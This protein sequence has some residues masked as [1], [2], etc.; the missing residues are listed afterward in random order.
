MPFFRDSYFFSFFFFPNADSDPVAGGAA[1]KQEDWLW[2]RIHRGLLGTHCSPLCQV[3]PRHNHDQWWKV[4]DFGL[5]FHVVIPDRVPLCTKS[6]FLSGKSFKL[7]QQQTLFPLRT[8][9]STP[10]LELRFNTV[11]PLLDVKVTDYNCCSFDSATY[12]NDIALLKLK[13]LPFEDKC[14]V[15]NP[16][17]SAVCVPWSTQLFQPNHTCS[18]SGWGR[19]AGTDSTQKRWTCVCVFSSSWLC[20]RGQSCSGSALGQRLPHRKLWEFLQAS[21]QARNDVCRWV[22]AAPPPPHCHHAV[23]NCRDG[24]ELTL[25]DYLFGLTQV[26]WTAAWTRVRETVVVPWSARTSWACP[27]CGASSAGGRGVVSRAFLE[28]IHR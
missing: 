16:A 20:S 15:D 21:L 3:R 17:I 5:T 25:T 11:S 1:G 13:K 8:S 22:C 10:G 4:W 24:P 12:E 14:F 19:N 18:I 9:S 2:R 23:N 27:T 7:K 6:S 26:I 28:F